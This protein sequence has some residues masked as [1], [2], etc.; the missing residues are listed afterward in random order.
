[1]IILDIT[2]LTAL[3]SLKS[4]IYGSF[5][6]KEITGTRQNGSGSQAKKEDR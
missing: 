1:M 5:C 4:R 3:L 6:L 2:R